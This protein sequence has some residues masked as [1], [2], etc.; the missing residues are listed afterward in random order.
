MQSLTLRIREETSLPPCLFWR[1]LI[2]HKTRGKATLPIDSETLVRVADPS[3]RGELLKSAKGL[4]LYLEGTLSHENPQALLDPFFIQVHDAIVRAG[5]KEI[6]IELARLEF[7][8]S[9]SFKSLISWLN[10]VQAL[11]AEKRY[12]LIFA[13][14]KARRWQTPSIHALRCFAL[15]LVESVTPQ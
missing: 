13:I 5:A 1:R 8:N 2:A 7:M 12:R 4:R 6:T 9:A 11:P 15:D 3:F 10:L 14:T